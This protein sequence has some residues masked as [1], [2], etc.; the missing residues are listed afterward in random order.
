MILDDPCFDAQW[1]RAAGHSG[2]GGAKLCECLAGAGPIRG[3]DIESWY[4]AWLA[5]V[6][7]VASSPWG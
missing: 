2:A 3:S 7:G 4:A 5:M 1:L 6:L